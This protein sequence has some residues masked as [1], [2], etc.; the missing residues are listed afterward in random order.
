MRKVHWSFGHLQHKK[1][2]IQGINTFSDKENLP[3]SALQSRL[4]ST[5]SH[6]EWEVFL[7]KTSQNMQKIKKRQKFLSWHL[8]SSWHSPSKRLLATYMKG[9]VCTKP[10]SA[11]SCD[12][13]TLLTRLE[14][15][16]SLQIFPSLTETR[17]TVCQHGRS[18]CQLHCILEHETMRF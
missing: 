9:H 17:W 7:Q 16:C 13:S 5:P 8:Q 11:R 15:E 6:G 4:Q 10:H 1:K 12:S 18:E 3:A 14:E 2:K